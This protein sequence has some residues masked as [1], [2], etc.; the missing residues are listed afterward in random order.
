MVS[1]LG[2]T[3]A[4]GSGDRRLVG[5]QVRGHGAA[6]G[7]GP[8]WGT[9]GRAVEQGH[10]APVPL[11][12]TDVSLQSQGHRMRPAAPQQQH[13]HNHARSYLTMPGFAA[14]HPTTAM[15]EP[16]QWC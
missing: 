4:A 5:R 15:W 7:L 2:S 11:I 14:P 6:L 3:P 1:T 9:L 8:C 16:R 13:W 12:P 10:T